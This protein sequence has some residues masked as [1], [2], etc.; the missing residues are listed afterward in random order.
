MRFEY[1][2][3]HG[4]CGAS[5]NRTHKVLPPEDF[6]SSASAGSAIAPAC[7]IVSQN[8]SAKSPISMVTAP[9][10]ASALLH[11]L[12]GALWDPRSFIAKGRY[13]NPQ[14]VM[15]INSM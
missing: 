1:G 12:A 11:V 8:P 3:S 4:C 15:P 10:V 9:R 5:G 14:V 6:K 13:N 7:G 2:G